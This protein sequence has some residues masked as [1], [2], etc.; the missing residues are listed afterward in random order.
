MLLKFNDLSDMERYMCFD[1]DF[2]IVMDNY[3]IN[4]RF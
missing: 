1:F 4:I 2:W 3:K